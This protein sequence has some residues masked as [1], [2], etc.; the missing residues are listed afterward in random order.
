[1]ISL[2]PLIKLIL[3]LQHWSE[4]CSEFWTDTIQPTDDPVGEF[5]RDYSLYTFEWK[6]SRPLIPRKCFITN[7]WL[8]GRRHYCV[9]VHDITGIFDIKIWI[10][11]EIGTQIKLML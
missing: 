7:D 5:I 9:T 6:I 3:V 1:M 2:P 4:T 8:W 10:G 11:L